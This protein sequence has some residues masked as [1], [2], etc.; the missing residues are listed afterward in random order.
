[1]AFEPVNQRVDVRGEE[2]WLPETVIESSAMNVAIEGKYDFDSNIDYTLGFALRDLRASASDN[3]GVM[4]DD[5]LGTQV[6]LR[7]FGKVNQPEY[8]YNRDAAKAHRRAA[9][10]AEKDRLRNALSNR[11]EGSSPSDSESEAKPEDE[12]KP[13]T[14]ATPSSEDKTSPDKPGRNAK[15]KKKDRNK[16]LFNPDDEDYL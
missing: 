4:E 15:K 16:D 10:A 11:G 3:V 6:F 12:T 14:P 9:F 8:A 13:V 1:M 7:M 5:G 2:V